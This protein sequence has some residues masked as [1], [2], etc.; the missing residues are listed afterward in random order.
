MKYNYNIL[1]LFIAEDK[2]RRNPCFKI[3]NY[4]CLYLFG[5]LLHRETIV[6][7]RYVQIQLDYDWTLPYYSASYA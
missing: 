1:L 3:F 6:K 5:I 7:L 4:R 2:C